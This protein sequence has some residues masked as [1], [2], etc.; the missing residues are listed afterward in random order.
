LQSSGGNYRQMNGESSASAGKFFT[1]NSSSPSPVRNVSR[2]L[3][4][5]RVIAAAELNERKIVRALI[6]DRSF[7]DSKH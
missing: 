7:R 5:N 1:G 6:E 2:L 3:A 4:L